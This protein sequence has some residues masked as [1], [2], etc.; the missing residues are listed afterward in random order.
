MEEKNQRRGQS[1]TGY[2][3]MLSVLSNLIVEVNNP[4]VKG[5]V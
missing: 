2:I 3:E 5:Y 4:H 1:S